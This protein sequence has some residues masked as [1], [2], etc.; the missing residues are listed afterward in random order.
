VGAG[1][2]PDWLADHQ[3]A[4]AGVTV[5]EVQEASRRYLAAAGLTTVVV[6]DAARVADQLRTL[7]PVEV[8]QGDGQA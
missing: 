7:A 3:R 8:T 6:G 2:P 1:L 5:D 4:L